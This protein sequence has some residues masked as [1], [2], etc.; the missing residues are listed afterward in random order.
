MS[1]QPRKVEFGEL[2]SKNKTWGSM[3]PD[4]PRGRKSVSIYSRSAPLP[5]AVGECTREIS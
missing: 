4:L 1:Q 3:A 5:L 2:K